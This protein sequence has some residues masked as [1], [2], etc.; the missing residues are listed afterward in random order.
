MLMLLEIASVLFIFY[1]YGSIYEVVDFYMYLNQCV[2]K[3]A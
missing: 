1:A 3:H 2:A